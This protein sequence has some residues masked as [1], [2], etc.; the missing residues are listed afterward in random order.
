MDTEFVEYC[1]DMVT[2]GIGRDVEPLSD[3]GVG[4]AVEEKPGELAFAGSEPVS[5][6]DKR[7]DI[8]GWGA[9]D[10][11]RDGAA[12]DG[13]PGEVGSVDGNPVT[14]WGPDA[15]PGSSWRGGGRFAGGFG[16][17]TQPGRHGPGGHQ[18]A[19]W[20]GKRPAPGIEWHSPAQQHNQFLAQGE[21]VTAAGL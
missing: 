14:G 8:G 17:G 18:L 4:Q 16:Q 3:L 11:N 19:I 7:G 6:E 2:D 15:H 20:I 12:R 1:F 5:M 9:L 21:R 10:G 13:H